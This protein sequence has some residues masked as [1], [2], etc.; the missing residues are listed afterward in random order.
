[1]IQDTANAGRG[2][3]NMVSDN[4]NQLNGLVINALKRAFE[5]SL[6]DCKVWLGK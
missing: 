6:K 1:M 2:S 3:Y 5:P 4:T